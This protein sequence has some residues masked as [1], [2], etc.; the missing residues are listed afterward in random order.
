MASRHPAGERWEAMD[1]DE[2]TELQRFVMGE[3][4]TNYR[5]QALAAITEAE[6]TKLLGWLAEEERKY[7]Q[8][9]AQVSLILPR[10]PG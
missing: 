9:G 2:D 10:L 4:I 8:L 1:T 3:N 5:R 6:R 7:A